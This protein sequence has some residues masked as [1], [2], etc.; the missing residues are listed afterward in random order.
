MCNVKY[1]RCKYGSFEN[2]RNLIPFLRA[3]HVFPIA[4]YCQFVNVN[5]GDGVNRVQEVIKWLREF[6]N[7]RTDIHDNDRTDEPVKTREHVKAVQVRKLNLEIDNRR[8]IF[9]LELKLS[10]EMLRE[11]IYECKW[12]VSAAKELEISY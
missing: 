2:I 8:A 3:Q 5:S 9:V 1:I 11:F 6:E 12:S 7:G 10:I 4:I